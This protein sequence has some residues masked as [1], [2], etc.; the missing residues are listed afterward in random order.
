MQLLHSLGVSEYGVLALNASLT[1]ISMWKGENK[2]KQ[3]NHYLNHMN[4]YNYK[5]LLIGTQYEK[6]K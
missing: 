2:T 4:N 6:S 5:N 3:G 1:N